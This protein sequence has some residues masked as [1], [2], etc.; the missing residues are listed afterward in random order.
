MNDERE[1]N[2]NN[3]IIVDCI[4]LRYGVISDEMG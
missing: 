3:R 1:C 4:T 2:I